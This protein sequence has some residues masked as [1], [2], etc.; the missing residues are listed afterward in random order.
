[1]AHYYPKIYAPFKRADSK[2]KYV[3]INEWATPE[4]EMLKDIDWIWTQK[5][6]GT[7]VVLQWNGD[8]MTLDTIKGHTDKSQF[9]QRTKDYLEK[10]F[11]TPEAETI[12]EDLYGENPVNVYGEFCSKDYNQNYGFLDGIFFPFDVQN[13]E[14]GKWWPRDAVETFAQ[15][16][17][18]KP[19]PVVFVGTIKQAVEWVKNVE[20]IWNQKKESQATKINNIGVWYKNYITDTAKGFYP[21]EG[22][23]GRPIVELLN[24]NGERIITKVKCKDYSPI[25]S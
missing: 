25:E 4:F 3:N 9:N 13:G 16:F 14:T 1:M 8:K 15:R 10:T 23:V 5:A 11:C 6:D 21:V 20:L 24:A 7:S 19:V 2:S 22:L 18:L 17:N 12:F